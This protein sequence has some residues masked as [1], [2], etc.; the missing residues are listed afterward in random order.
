M[1]AAGIPVGAGTDATRVASY[2]PW[3]SLSWLV[4]GRTVGGLSLYPGANRVSREKAL[5]L[6]THENTWFSNELGKKGQ[7]KAGQLADLAVLS[8]DYFNVPESAIATLGSVLTILGGTVVHGEGD[9]ARL[10]PTL[11]PPMPDW[12][13]VAAFGGY[14]RAPGTRP[15]LANACGCAS[16]CAIH[17]HDHAAALGATVPAADPQSFWGSLGCG[18]WAV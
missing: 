5:R 12:S 18:C 15:T 2:N 7:I 4:T 16:G 14:H 10:A 11:P 1:L 9:F 3:V 8:A 17:G 6:W 13:P